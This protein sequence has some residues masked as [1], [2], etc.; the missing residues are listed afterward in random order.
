VNQSIQ[1]LDGA[2]YAVD[3]KSLKIEAIFSGQLINCY[4]NGADEETLLSIYASQQ[5]DIEEL[6]EKLIDDECF[7]SSGDIHLNAEQLI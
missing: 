6:L 2:V 3:K 1:I 7:D 4:I 5:F